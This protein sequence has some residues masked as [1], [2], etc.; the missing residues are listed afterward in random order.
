MSNNL[1]Q[2]Y[3]VL[4]M[5]IP[6]ILKLVKLVYLQGYAVQKEVVS[7]ETLK[8]EIKIIV[9]CIYY[10]L[11]RKQIIANL[12]QSTYILLQEVFMHE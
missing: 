9:V 4:N 6:P 5:G 8:N 10:L 12:Q 1:F 11:K 3:K 2:N 7:I